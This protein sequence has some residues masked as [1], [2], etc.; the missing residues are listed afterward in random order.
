MSKALE[1]EIPE[2]NIQTIGLTLV[3]TSSLIQHKFS[4]KAKIQIL[5]KQMK[6]ATKAKEARNP[7]AE[8]E[9]SLYVIKDGGFKYEVQEGVGVVKFAGE[10]GVPALW[11]K[12]AI[13]AAARNVNDL[14][15]TLLRGAVFVSGRPEDGLIPVR[16][17][18]L[19]MRED[20]V[21]I[22]KGSTDLRYRG[23]LIGWEA[24]VK[25]KFNAD[26]LSA[27]Q[28]VN[29]LKISGF[30][31]GLGEWR[32]QKSGEHGCFDVRPANKK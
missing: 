24:D 22:G 8:F 26:V 30:S 28:V 2:P 15:M 10:I 14:P 12:Q 19:Q 11:I 23:E 32:P 31:V 20:I 18:Q 9:R 27:E 13:V 6:K 25:V 4:E 16:Y 21:R 5:N 1:I 17:E 3:G 29:L 7:K